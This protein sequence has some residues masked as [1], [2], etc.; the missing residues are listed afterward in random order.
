MK[1]KMGMAADT[2]EISEVGASYIAVSIVGSHS[3]IPSLIM[4]CAMA[5]TQNQSSF[6][7]Q[8]N[9]HKEIEAVAGGVSVFASAVS[10]E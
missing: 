1:L 10:E 6:S 9:C 8:I 5:A 2:I 3:V 4:P 7:R